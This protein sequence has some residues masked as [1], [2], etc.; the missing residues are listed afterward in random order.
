MV[1]MISGMEKVVKD[2]TNLTLDRDQGQTL[3]N[4]FKNQ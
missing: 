1:K 4:I 2:I 3:H